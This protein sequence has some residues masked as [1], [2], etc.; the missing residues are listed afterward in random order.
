MFVRIVTCL[1]SQTSKKMGYAKPAE[2][3]QKYSVSNCLA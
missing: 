1:Y 2:L 3:L